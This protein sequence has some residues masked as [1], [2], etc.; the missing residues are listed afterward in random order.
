MLTLCLAEVQLA[1]RLSGKESVPFGN[2]LYD[3]KEN[4][5]SA[6]G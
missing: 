1:R 3:L 2:Y 6:E 5:Q 4:K